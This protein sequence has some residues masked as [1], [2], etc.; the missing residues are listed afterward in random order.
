M[1]QIPPY[2]REQI[3]D[4]L[5]KGRSYVLIADEVD[6]ARGT[7]VKIAQEF[8][9]DNPLECDLCGKRFQ[10]LTA[11][12]S[13]R[14]QHDSNGGS[15]RI[16]PRPRISEVPLPPTAFCAC[17][18]GNLTVFGNVTELTILGKSRK[19]ICETLGITRTHLK[20]ILRNPPKLLV[21]HQRQGLGKDVAT[22]RAK[23]TFAERRAHQNRQTAR[24]LRK[25][26][27]SGQV[28]RAEGYA[29]R[30]KEL[31]RVAHVLE[32]KAFDRLILAGF[33]LPSEVPVQP[34]ALLVRGTL[35]EVKAQERQERVR[36]EVDRKLKR[37]TD[38]QTIDYL[39]RQT[40]DNWYSDR[41]PYNMVLTSM[42]TSKSDDAW[43]LGLGVWTDRIEA[44][45]TEQPSMDELYERTIAQRL[46]EHAKTPQLRALIDWA[47]A[48]PDDISEEER[49]VLK[50]HFEALQK[51][52]GEL[53]KRLKPTWAYYDRDGKYRLDDGETFIWSRGVAV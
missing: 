3:I 32:V 9:A 39:Q 16:T 49:A 53:P 11:L 7:V 33:S 41:T 22:L 35:N 2:K 48:N 43:N 51:P 26:A 8:D 45:L 14:T 29:R 19:E 38:R 34:T 5:H 31:E 12:K 37:G 23:A 40:A 13:H 25:A 36:L 30:A 44:A 4:L 52:K 21:G 47:I 17:G 27:E 6:V 20:S 28:W 10:R 24:T 18:C 15:R 42:Q 50:E 1:N 46:I